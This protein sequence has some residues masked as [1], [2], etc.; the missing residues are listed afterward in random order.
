MTGHYIAALHRPALDNRSSYSHRQVSSI[1]CKRTK[2]VRQK[3]SPSCDRSHRKRWWLTCV[4]H[5]RDGSKSAKSK[6]RCRTRHALQR[7]TY[8]FV[9]ASKD[10]SG[11]HACFG[12]ISRVVRRGLDVGRAV[13]R[14]TSDS[15]KNNR[16]SY[17]L[18]P[19]QLPVAS[20]SSPLLGEG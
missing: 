17:V 19:P 10:I 8:L 11:G 3:L 13:S 14:Y 18:S 7:I 20:R 6:S 4:L 1:A 2:K 15:Y 9:E 5:L 12:G 16:A